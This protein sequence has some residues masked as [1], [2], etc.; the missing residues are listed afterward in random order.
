[1]STPSKAHESTRILLLG[2]AANVSLAVL[3]ISAG[4]LC[5]SRSLEAD[6][7]H[8]CEDLVGD[9]LALFGIVM[10][11]KKPGEASTELLIGSAMNVLLFAGSLQM[12]YE[13]IRALLNLED[14]TNFDTDKGSASWGVIV[15][16]ISICVKERMCQQSSSSQHRNRTLS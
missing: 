11:Q 9:V 12:V 5:K 8:S 16:V 13:S 7:Y 1:M 6:G 2:L 15:A 14:A 3:K 10:K 4:Y